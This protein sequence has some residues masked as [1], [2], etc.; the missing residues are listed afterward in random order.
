M[1][2]D[3]NGILEDL[4]ARMAELIASSPAKDLQANLGA[5]LRQGFSRLDLATREEL[6]LQTELLRRAQT[7]LKELEA[8]VAQIEARQE[9]H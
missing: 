7:R 3:L 2:K 8:R 1:A 4:Q 6:E 9:T 5:L